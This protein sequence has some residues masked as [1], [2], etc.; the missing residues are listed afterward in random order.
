ME[1]NTII[2]YLLAVVV[3]ITL[4]LIG[5]GGSILSVPILVYI[6]HVEPALA[7]AYSLFAVGTSAL[8]GGVQK[9]KQKLVDFKKVFLFGIP[10]ILSVF[11]TRKIIV[12]S[13]PDVIFSSSAFT[14]HKSV[15]I[16]IVFAIVMIMA[17]VRM[18]KP[19][20][21]KI[22][23]DDEKLNYKAIFLQGLIIGFVA[24]FVG[25]GG[26]F[27]I[28][29]AL[30]FFAKTPMKMAV[31][32]SLFII[33]AQSLIG[34]T[35]DISNGNS[36]DWNLILTFTLCSVIGI[37]IGNYLSKKFSGEKLKTGFGWFVLAMGIY[38]ILK[39]VFLK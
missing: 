12:P 3:G 28:I 1:T 24:G 20:K 27:L 13:I 17:S 25:A 6:M 30:L 21:E 26:G 14:L 9:A 8:V 15:L 36:L 32:T 19:L 37:F 29:P 35:G 23:N 33:A 22:I 11:I 10:T 38:I 18:I 2:G 5:S 4:G 34:F 7:T 31:G 39:E 16:M